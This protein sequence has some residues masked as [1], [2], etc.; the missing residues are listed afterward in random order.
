MLISIPANRERSLNDTNK[1][2]FINVNRMF[3]KTRFLQ[4]ST[5]FIFT[6]NVWTLFARLLWIF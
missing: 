5:S 3:I 6:Q 4:H 2:S 1:H